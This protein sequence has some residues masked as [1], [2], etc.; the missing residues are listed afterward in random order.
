M[1]EIKTM[2]GMLNILDKMLEEPVET[3][4]KKKTC[5]IHG[6]YEFTV[7]RY[8]DGRESFND[9]CPMCEN[10]RQEREEKAR[11]EKW[12]REYHE[13]TIKRY[14]ESRIDP[15]Y[16]EMDFDDF[17]IKTKGQECAKKA[18]EE[19]IKS[20][21][22][23][24]ILLGSFG[25]GKT[26]LANL[27][28]KYLGGKIYTMYEIANTIR[29]SYVSGNNKSELDIVTE[30][31]ELPFLAID[32]VGKIGNTEAVRNWF[33]YI[34][35]KR[36]IKNIPTLIIGNLH[37]KSQCNKGGCDLCFENYFGGDV[38]SRFTENTKIVIMKSPDERTKTNT[39]EIMGDK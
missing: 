28:C 21:N 2:S 24:V 27:V 20:R 31:A 11:K 25:V 8:S 39:L 17:E 3:F 32:E 7:S 6:E 34:I 33:S 14:T 23:K 37:L 12:E 29:R 10:E 13:Q 26:M 38:L 22:G 16:F 15:K 19:M 35:D 18:V 5:P 36:H 9:A 1:N 30:L 4:K